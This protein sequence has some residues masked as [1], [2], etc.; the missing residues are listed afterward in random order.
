MQKTVAYTVGCRIPAAFY[1]GPRREIQKQTLEVDN[2]DTLPEFYDLMFLFVN[3]FV[4]TW[5]VAKT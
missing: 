1:A 5:S 3:K 2:S 4:N